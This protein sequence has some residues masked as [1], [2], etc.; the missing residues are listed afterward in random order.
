M[1][2]I[3]AFSSR[4]AM[5]FWHILTP[6]WLPSPVPLLLPPIHFLFPPFS[7]L[8]SCL[9]FDDPMGFVRIVRIYF[10]ER[11]LPTSHYTIKE[12]VSHSPSDH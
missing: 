11:G 4:Y 5:Y 6:P 7:L 3:T 1:S 10:Q 12:N 9:G 2:F 8:F